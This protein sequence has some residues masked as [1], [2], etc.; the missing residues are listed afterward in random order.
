MNQLDAMRLFVRV[1]EQASFTRA[2]EDLGV[3]KSTVSNAV[4]AL[5]NRLGTRLLQRTTRRV[6]LTHDGQ[7]Y[8]EGCRQLLAEFEEVHGM[9]Q[10]SA[11]ALRGRLR[12]DMPGALARTLVL[13]RLPQF[14][15]AHPHI[16][17]ELS[18]TDR[19]VDVVA[20]GFDCVVRSGPLGD[21]RLL[22][23]PLGT[24]LVINCASPA[25]LQR[26]G[27]PDTLEALAGH[28]LIHYVSTLGARSPG[29]E[30]P[31]AGGYR[32]LPMRGVLTVN[33]ADAY[34]Q[35]CLAGL[36]II[37]SPAGSLRDHLRSGRLVEILPQYRPEPMPVSI[38]YAHRRHLPR[39]VQ[40]FMDWIT[41]TMRPYLAA[42]AD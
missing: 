29:F 32:T 9:F 31:A 40:A 41:A 7:A 14:L 36:G 37:Q 1:A 16:E 28:Q 20:E 23:R 6:H 19:Y 30:Y 11:Q 3:R 33:S 21:S 18:S 15:G 8:Y 13:P 12:V 26:H 5:E 24:H 35:A 10:R 25:Y 2:A 4:Q 34:E 27:T 39:R 38:V 22:A 17:L 42:C